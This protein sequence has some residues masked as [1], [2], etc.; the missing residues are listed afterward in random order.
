MFSTQNSKVLTL[1]FLGEI[2]GDY[3]GS[4]AGSLVG[5]KMRDGLPGSTPTNVRYAWCGVGGAGGS[6]SEGKKTHEL[7][8]SLHVCL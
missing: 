4:L 8:I 2:R 5:C 7:Y 3:G 6:F 1:S